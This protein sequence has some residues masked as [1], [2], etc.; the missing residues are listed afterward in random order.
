MPKGAAIPGH[1]AQREITSRRR[2]PGRS[3]S[4]LVRSNRVR[5]SGLHS[6]KKTQ[7]LISGDVPGGE[8]IIRAGRVLRS[9][10]SISGRRNWSHA[11]EVT[12]SRRI[13]R[14]AFGQRAGRINWSLYNER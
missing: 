6:V 5:V 1:A 9:T 10:R 4:G 2:T 3:P 11:R 7:S 13:N 8:K 12:A 14:K